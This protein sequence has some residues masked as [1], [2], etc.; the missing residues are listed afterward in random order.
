MDLSK[1]ILIE[2]R[3]LHLPVQNGAPIRQV[4]VTAEGEAVR[5]F[6]IELAQDEPDFWVACALSPFQGKPAR[7]EVLGEDLDPAFLEPIVQ[8]DQFPGAA[9][10]Y[11]E[12]LRPQLHFSSRRGWHNDPNGLLFYGGKYHL[13]YQHNPYGV[14]W[15]NM[16]WGHAVSEDLVH[17]R[18]LGDALYPDELGTAFSGCGV[19]DW[20]NTSGMQKGK[21]PPLVCVYTSA[22]GTSPE[23]AEQPFTQSLFYSADGGETW[24]VYAGNPVLG[25]IAGENRDPKVI[26]HAPSAQWVMAL[27]LDGNDY[28]LYGSPDLKAWTK[29]CDVVLPDCTECPDFFPLAVDG[30]PNDARWVFWGANGTYLLGDFDGQS[31]LPD[32]SAQ[33]YD[34]GGNAY[35]AQTWSDAPGGDPTLGGARIQIVWLRVNPPGMPFS[36]QMTVPCELTLRRTPDG[37]RLCSWPV[38]EIEALRKRSFKHQNLDLAEGENP[39]KELDADL[40]DVS[41]EFKARAPGPRLC[42][43]LRG[44]EM[45]Y[46]PAAEQLSCQGRSLP[47][48]PVEGRVR[49]RALLDRCSLEV[50][51]NDGLVTLALGVVP[52]AVNRS[53]ALSSAGGP[54]HIVD[55]QAHSL[56][57]IWGDG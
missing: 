15:G 27:Y 30:D 49:L 25:H 40:L 35:A 11:R 12:A 21:H 9:E 6:E 2:R 18:E 37:V 26:W 29:L 16:H 45:V 19:V 22:G 14:K 36:Q 54:T 4:R 56:C 28:A 47:L 44:I 7:I 33:R 1:D 32:G 24:G 55:L 5:S 51:G 10:M 17:W 52:D 13:F 43:S 48:P 8:S 46:D 57:S 34:W 31:F 53:H 39:L 23:S 42:L 20:E 3:F 38:R 50:W 41:V